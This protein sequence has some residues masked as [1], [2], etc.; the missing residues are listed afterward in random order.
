MTVAFVPPAGA[1]TPSCFG[2]N[3][4]KTHLDSNGFIT[5]TKGND[6][7]VGTKGD[8]VIV[9]K[10]G[11]DLICGLAGDDYVVDFAGNDKINGGKGEDKIDFE[12]AKKA[13]T[14]NLAAHSASGGGGTDVVKGFEDLIGTNYN[15]QLTGDANGNLMAGLDGNDVMNGGAA[16]D[17]LEGGP[18]DDSLDGGT[19]AAGETTSDIAW[20]HASFADNGPSSAV[21]V[22]LGAGTATGGAGT[23]H[24]TNIAGIVG[25]KFDDTLTGNSKSNFILGMEGD[26]TIDGGGVQSAGNFDESIYWFAQSAVTVNLQT[27]KAIGGDGNDTLSNISGTYGSND[28]NDTIIGDNQ[29][30]Y[31]DGAGSSTAGTESINGGGGDDWM[32]SNANNESFDGGPGTYDLVDYENDFTGPVSVDL[33]T[34]SGTGYGTD[35]LANV[36]GVY[37]TVFDDHLTGDSNVNYLFGWIGNDTI[38]GSGGND[39]IDAGQGFF[40]STF[41]STGDMDNVNGGDGSDKCINADPPETNNCETTTG[42]ITPQP[43][44][45][46]AEDSQTF[47]RSF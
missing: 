26:D 4:T 41:H 17:I 13:V 22:D 31:L 14:L 29:N 45:Q 1:A 24:L 8:D 5:G 11:R 23:D 40:D 25:S 30:N 38:A 18:G 28:F 6:V 47:R 34:G 44:T 20:Y 37:G 35:T 19:P 39:E 46:T 9:G 16:L 27:G 7:I 10:G 42:S 2:K 43:L 36:E 33:S 32:V 21:T 12:L 15:D 3:A